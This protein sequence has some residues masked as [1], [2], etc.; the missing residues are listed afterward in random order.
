MINTKR[1]L[2]FLLVPLLT[3]AQV[4]V[5]GVV[6]DQNNES[7]PF[8]NVVFKGSILGTVSDEYGQFYIESE[9][10][11]K[12]LEVSFVGYENKTVAVTSRNMDI[13]VVL[14]ETTDRLDEVV[15]YSGRI[16]NKGNPAIEILKKVW[17]RKRKN[18]TYLFSQYEYDKYEKLEFDMNN[19]DSTLMEKKL[20][21]GIEFI[22]NNV[23]TSRVSGKTYLPI[24]INEA[25]YKTYGDNV[26]KREREDL[27]ANKNSGFESNQYVIS[28]IKDLYNEYNIYDN[29]IKI[30]EKRFVSPIS[31]N[32]PLTYNYVL[33]DSAYIDNKWCYNIIYYPRR[34]N[35]LTFKG[36]FWVSDTT[37]AVKEI[38]MQVN[39]S[40]NINWVK[41][42]Y[43][44]QEFEVLNDSVFLL[45]RDY[46]M[47]DFSLNKKDETVG[48]YG[49]RTT[50]YDNYLFDKDKGIDFYKE[51]V[52][53]FDEEKF[54]KDDSFWE[55][56]RQE[57]LTKDQE[58]I[59]TMLD[60]L[61]KTPK[62]KRYTGLATTLVSGY[63]EC[64]NFDFGP[65]TSFIGQNDVEGLRLS[66]GART[67][68]GQ[69]DPWRLQAY[70]AYGFGDNQFK[71]G[72]TGKWMIEKKNRIII[73]GGNKR[74]I[75]QTG[76]NLTTTNDILGNSF[77][78]SAFFTVGANDKLSSV[79]LSNAFV[80][81]EPIKN[82]TF[83]LGSTYKDLKPASEKFSLDYLDENGDVQSELQ[84][85]TLDFTL[86][87]RPGRKTM[88]YGVERTSVN[89]YYSDILISYHKGFKGPFESDFDYNKL[90][91]YYSQPFLIPG[92]GKSLVTFEAGKIFDPVP[93]GLL[94]VVP[95][96]QSIFLVP[97]T[98]SLL[99]Y[100][101][102]VTDTYTSLHFEQH[103]N[104]RLFSLVPL[105][106]KTNIRTVGT[107]RAIWG[108]I[109]EESIAINSS[110]VNYVAPEDVYFEYG[111]GVEN[112]FKIVRLDCIWRGNYRTLP[113]ARNFGLRVSFG[114]Y[115]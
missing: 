38:S 97:N 61:S 2:F 114:F 7:I 115:F 63:I 47:S 69:N 73:G 51:K 35:Q 21:D 89:R 15:I 103:F 60:T 87:L 4:R 3:V 74:D 84:Q 9:T 102:F 33:T 57:K 31:S 83:K 78:S 66:V 94:S 50:M 80:S 5:K 76:V 39:K 17:E 79:N 77:A 36:D 11:Y 112:I 92:M 14:Q 24:F 93:L 88:D 67:Y 105:L 48:V 68:F 111:V 27:I 30:F 10:D 8:A 42:L 6:V 82:I 26:H 58:G 81:I 110:D 54:H 12:E 106:R 25:V 59:Y 64:N 41:D 101:D 43:L 100:Y 34:M 72:I 65:I 104:G 109:S 85:Y 99:D 44:E 52:E 55:E 19:I 98:Y 46:M 113:N 95:G 13:R 37:F 56:N 91:L 107:F 86:R 49:H 16:K 45:K 28:F 22:F 40:A 20:F 32:G 53:V 90:Q 70:T 96:N 108:D 29:S 71:Y 62:F 1:I 18:G 23:D 75:E